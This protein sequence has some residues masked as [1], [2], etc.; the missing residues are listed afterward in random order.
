MYLVKLKIEMNMADLIVKIVRATSPPPDHELHRYA[1]SSNPNLA[2]PP[3]SRNNTETSKETTTSGTYTMGD[4]I[5]LQ[6]PTTLVESPKPGGRRASDNTTMA[7][8]NQNNHNNSN[9]NNNSTHSPWELKQ[10]PSHF[11]VHDVV[12]PQFPEAELRKHSVAEGSVASGESSNNTAREL[13][14][15]V[16]IRPPLGGRNFSELTQ[17][18]LGAGY[19]TKEKRNTICREQG[20]QV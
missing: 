20:S 5:L 9:N 15:P 19:V 7:T 10:L 11:D 13:L 17:L 4:T 1:A 6:S 8:T 18:E 12:H 3:Q 16:P 2:R 14:A